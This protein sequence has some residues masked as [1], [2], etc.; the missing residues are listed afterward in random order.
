MSHS[1][2]EVFE[3]TRQPLDPA[4][5][6]VFNAAA[7][8][9]VGQ[10]LSFNMETQLQTEWCWAAVA[11]SVAR[12][13]M[14]TNLIQQCHVAN[15]EFGRDDCCG[16]GVFTGCN[17]P[18][19]LDTALCQVGHLSRPAEENS[20]L[21]PQVESEIMNQRPLGCRIGWFDGGGHFVVLHG[22]STDFSTGSPKHWVAVADPLFGP[23][24]Y[25]IDNFTDSYRQE[26]SWTHSYF[27]Q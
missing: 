4:G 23:S 10:T 21:F 16:G 22:A 9:G 26:G 17:I 13:Y 2:P 11:V 20:T 8:P 3:Q 6:M 18:H 12:F 25:L 27:T 14:P 24:D 1:L 15:G 19:T 5:N 7:I